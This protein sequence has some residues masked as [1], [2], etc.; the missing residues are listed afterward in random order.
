VTVTV[1]RVTGDRLRQ[2]Y[3][4]LVIE[5]DEAQTTPPQANAL[6]DRLHALAKEMRRSDEGRFAIQ[7]LLDDPVAAVRLCAATDTLGWAP[8]LAEP[9]LASL[10]DEPS[11]HA[12]S[13]KWTLRSHRAGRLNLDW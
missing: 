10:E 6:F 7:G 1:R 4:A 5:W 8:E 12:V 13:A 9:V 3:R 2:Q 11:L